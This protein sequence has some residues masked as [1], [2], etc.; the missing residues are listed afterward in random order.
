MFN[1]YCIFTDDYRISSDKSQRH[2][3]ETR[4]VFETSGI[5]YVGVTVSG[6]G[7]APVIGN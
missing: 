4:R 6:V 5:Y 7:A 1:T 2:V 3:L